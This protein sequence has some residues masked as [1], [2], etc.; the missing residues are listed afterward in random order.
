MKQRDK[1][2]IKMVEQF[3]V[4]TRDHIVKVFFQGQKQAVNNAN[5][6]LRRLTLKKYIRVHRNV[7]GQNMYYANEGVKI[8]SAKVY[9]HLA[10]ADTYLQILA[11]GKHDLTEFQVEPDFGK[12]MPNPDAYCVFRERG[13][14]IEIQRS[15]FSKAQ[16]E[17]K[18]KRYE[19]YYESG[20]WKDYTN[21][22]PIILVITDAHLPLESENENI[23]FLQ[24]NSWNTF[25]IRTEEAKHKEEVKKAKVKLN[26]SP[27]KL[28]PK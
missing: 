1:Q 14:Y 9:H 21:T 4:L 15:T 19:N 12:E 17:D 20:K 28:S 26:Q 13:F 16:L 18:V 10:I 5:V 25:M 22:F 3:K 8:D 23:R 6:V 11:S 27:I 24:V 2:I 7:Y